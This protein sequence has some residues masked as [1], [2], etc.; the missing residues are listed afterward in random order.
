M[1]ALAI[2][3]AIAPHY[4]GTW[5]KEVTHG[6]AVIGRV[7]LDRSGRLFRYFPGVDNDVAYVFVHDDFGSLLRLI[8]NRSWEL[9]L[10][11]I[12]TAQRENG[13]ARAGMVDEALPLAALAD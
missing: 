10:Q 7:A 13:I 9:E 1:H 8:E 6:G 3:S 12:K 11:Q 4:V 2:Q 5:P